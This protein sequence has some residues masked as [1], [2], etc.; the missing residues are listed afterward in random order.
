MVFPGALWLDGKPAWNLKVN[1]FMAD[2]GLC[3]GGIMDGWRNHGATSRAAEVMRKL[4]ARKTFS[5]TEVE[6][7]NVKAVKAGADDSLHGRLQ[8]QTPLPLADAELTLVNVVNDTGRSVPGTLAERFES[9]V[10]GVARPSRS[11][12]TFLISPF[13]KNPK[14]SR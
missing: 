5:G 9:T 11:C 14:P 4:N 10:A 2:W 1:G 7:L 3:G 12:I 13:L 8:I 6:L